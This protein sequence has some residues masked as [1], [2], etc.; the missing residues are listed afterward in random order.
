LDDFNHG[1]RTDGFALRKNGC[2]LAIFYKTDWT[3]FR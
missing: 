2:K 3:Q 1:I